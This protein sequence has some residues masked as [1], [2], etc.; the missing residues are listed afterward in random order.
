[1]KALVVLSGGQ[2]SATCMAW[3]ANRFDQVGAISFFYKQKHSRELQSAE[4]IS[5]LFSAEHRILEMPVLMDN[6]KSGLT[7]PDLNVSEVDATT[8]LPKSFVPGR[9]LIFL[10]S[11]ASI[12]I[13]NG[14]DLLVT[15]VCQ[16]DYSGY[17]DCRR[18]T[19]DAV[20]LAIQLGNN[21]PDFKI[22]T[23]LMYLTKAETVLLAKNEP[24]GM[25]AVALSWTCY[26]GGE[27]PCGECPA[28]ALRI[29]GFQEA[30]VA[31][32]SL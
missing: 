2:D 20:E 12:A 28:C 4:K 1:M 32:P 13:S 25:E 16:T 17:P 23:P 30:G 19:I 18:E 14:Y 31:D 9:N 15:G 3:A 7:N 24:K 8:G 27:A 10:T 6:A 22:E 29:K 5:K 11:A 21:R 26:N